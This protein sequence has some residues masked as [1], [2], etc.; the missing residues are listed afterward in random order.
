MI[1]RESIN[2]WRGRAPWSNNSQV[3]QDL[4]LS[5]ALVELFSN[6]VIASGFAL[7]GGTAINK[8][9]FDPAVRYSEDIDLVQIKA[10][11]IGPFIDQIR[12]TLDPWL[13]RP[14]WKQT[15]FLVTFRYRFESEEHPPATLRLKIEINTREHI[16]VFGHERIPYRVDSDWFNGN[17]EIVTYSLDE[18]LATKLRALY[19]RKKGR[20]LFDLAIGLNDDS[21]DSDRIINA[22][23]EY[24]RHGGDQIP[25]ILFEQNLQDKLIDPEFNRDISPLLSPGHPW[26]LDDAARIVSERLISRLPD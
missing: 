11:P 25:R 18:L 26:D 13:G 15:D 7:R 20:D 4:V 6:P 24:V 2:E 1:P 8:L 19:R 9:H 5:R 3:E 14:R 17:A 12:A 23:S 10:G 22:F 21:A 16:T